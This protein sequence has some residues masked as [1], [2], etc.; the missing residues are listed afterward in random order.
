MDNLKEIIEYLETKEVTDII[1]CMKENEKLKQQIYLMRNC[2]N[3]S[4]AIGR[5]T[6]LKDCD[7]N[8]SG[9]EMKTG[10]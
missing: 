8:Y 2:R 3:C 1:D 9:W 6:C 10:G 5:N 7:N 4:F